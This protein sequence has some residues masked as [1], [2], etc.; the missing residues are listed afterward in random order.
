MRPRRQRA[1][2]HRGPYGHDVTG[3]DVT[4][5]ITGQG[6]TAMTPELEPPPRAHTTEHL[7]TVPLR[8]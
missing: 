6:V 2:V 1:D 4:Q 5:G 8:A 3:H 7:T